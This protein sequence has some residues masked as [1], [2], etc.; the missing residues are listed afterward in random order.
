MTPRARVLVTAVSGD[1]GQAIVKALRIGQ[2]GP[3]EC[4]GCDAEPRGIGAAF[5]ETF[6]QV[7]VA[8]HPGY[9]ARIAELASVLGVDAVIPASEA[10]IA[11][12]SATAAVPA[13]PSGV[14]VICQPAP[15]VRQFGD[16]LRCMEAL[17]GRVPLAPFA[18]GG[19]PAS[20]ARLVVESGFPLVVKPR[21][22][23]GSRQI[24]VVAH[25]ADLDRALNATPAPIVQQH[26]DGAAGEYSVGLFVCD[27][28]ETAMAFRRTLGPAGC[29]WSAETSE[30]A[31]V[32]QYARAVASAAG[33][34]GSANIQV[35][36]GHAGVRLLEI[37]PRFSSLAAARALCGFADVEWSLAVATGRRPAMPPAYRTLRFRRFIDEMIDIGGGFGVV[38]DWRP[39]ALN[40]AGAFLGE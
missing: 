28:F 5:T 33:L 22:S 17:R 24:R 12:L 31:E 26:L 4:H 8:G 16:K 2:Q 29:S 13:L 27:L 38:A 30:D 36:K 34:R 6:H 11:A 32:L 3:I 7:P 18:D 40:Q 9:A 19:D 23:S 35:R 10:E 20:V 1:L 14:P 39:R 15:W 37:N 25:Q 21:R